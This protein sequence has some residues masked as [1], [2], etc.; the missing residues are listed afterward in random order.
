MAACLHGIPLFKTVQGAQGQLLSWDMPELRKLADAGPAGFEALMGYARVVHA[1]LAAGAELSQHLQVHF[2]NSC[3]SPAVCLGVLAVAS[4]SSTADHAGRL[5]SAKACLCLSKADLGGRSQTYSGFRS[6][7]ASVRQGWVV[8]A[9]VL[10]L[11]PQEGHR[12]LS[13]LQQWQLT[14]QLLGVLHQAVLPHWHSTTGFGARL[15]A[16][17]VQSGQLPQLLARSLPPH[18]GEPCSAGMTRCCCQL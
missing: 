13:L 10:L 2:C 12:H 7:G 17:L 8:F 3:C 11:H 14:A 15:A 5:D 1:L 6:L 16:A 18:A 9:V 4:R